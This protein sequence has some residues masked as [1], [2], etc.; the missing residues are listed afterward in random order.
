MMKMF[1][2]K[3]CQKAFPG[4]V[5]LLTLGVELSPARADE[6]WGSDY[7]KVVYQ[8]DRGKTAIWTYGDS[9]SGTLFIDGLAGQ[10]KDRGT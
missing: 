5:I 3:L 10:F 1:I 9:L 2:N 4:A 8:V 6:V 7:G